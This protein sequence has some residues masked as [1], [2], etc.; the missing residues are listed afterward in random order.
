MQ[1]AGT[2]SCV[3][4][5]SPAH[6]GWGIVR[7][8]MLVPESY[9][10][11]VC[12][13]ACGRH[14]AISAKLLGY[15]DRLSYLYLDEADIVS[16]GY[17]ALIIESV[18]E[19][20]AAIEKPKA[21]LIVVSCLDDL[22][23][24]DHRVILSKLKENHP[25]V[26]FSMGHMNPLSSEGKLPPA[27]NIQRS[28]YSFL[29]PSKEKLPVVNL[30]GC[31]VPP[32]PGCELYPFLEGLGFG[33]GHISRCRTFA[34]YL[35][36][37]SCGLN[38]V[39]SPQAKTA[40]EEMKERLGIDWV[41]A[42]VSYDPGEIEDNYSRIAGSLNKSA[43][44]D[45][46]PWRGRLAS[47]LEETRVAVGGRKIVIDDAATIRP[48]SLAKL[49]FQNGFNVAEICAE[50]CSGMENGAFRWLEQNSG[51]TVTEHTKHTAPVMRKSD[52]DTL[53]IGFEC[54]YL[55]G[56]AHVVDQLED[57][58]QYGYGGVMLLLDKMKKAS[59]CTVNLQ[60]LIQDYGLVV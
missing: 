42:P 21:L 27:V 4:Y 9:Q 3:A 43:G 50:A 13:S 11:F 22:L 40:A 20:F 41:Y 24:T 28:I 53:A 2:E 25:D 44:F 52:P 16:G 29:E 15:K 45:F 1:A 14:G 39:I 37:S 12:P 59:S 60:G 38:L 33:I 34:E 54:A 58:A 6:G 32:G 55:H 26:Q 18:D 19:L 36:L 48:F 46:A 8:G 49:L 57:E 10:L 23:G 30:L 5:S 31:H 47:A 35:T 7:V 17:E 51:I 56:A